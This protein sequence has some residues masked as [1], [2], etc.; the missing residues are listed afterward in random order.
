LSST[1]CTARNVGEL[2]EGE[3][4]FA[5]GIGDPACGDQM[6]LW[7]QVSEETHQPHPLGCPG[8]IAT[9]SML[10]ELAVGRTLEQA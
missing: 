6:R 1:S 10:T 8:A 9:S 5:A 7:I 4:V 3:G 2:P